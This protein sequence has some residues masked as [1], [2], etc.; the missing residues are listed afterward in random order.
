MSDTQ[1][2]LSTVSWETAPAW[3][4]R[5]GVRLTETRRPG[6]ELWQRYGRLNLWHEFSGVDG[7][8]FDG[9]EMVDTR[10]GGTVLDLGAGLTAKASQRASFYLDGS[11]RHSVGGGDRKSSG[12]FGTVGLRLNW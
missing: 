10:F 3:T 11:Y 1:D 2:A 9:N 5:L 4:G 6:G 12:V 7:I 8:S